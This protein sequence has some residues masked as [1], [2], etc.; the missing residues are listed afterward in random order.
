[1]SAEI[2]EMTPHMLQHAGVVSDGDQYHDSTAIFLGVE[3][4]IVSDRFRKDLGDV[5]EL[6]ESIVQVGLLNPITVES[7]GDGFRLIAGERRLTAYRKLGLAEIPAR[8][9]ED[10]SDAR[11]ALIAERDENTAR[12]EMLPSEKAALAMALEEMEKPAAKERQVSALNKGD[13]RSVPG[14]GTGHDSREVVA[15]AVDLSPSTYTRLKTLVNLSTDAEQPVEV[16][17]AAR[18]ALEQI[19]KGAPIRRGY[20]KVKEVRRKTESVTTEST[21]PEADGRTQRSEEIAAWHASL[22]KKYPT[23]KHAYE[24]EGHERSATLNAFKTAVRSYGIKYRFTEV[25]Y[26]KHAHTSQDRLYRASISLETAIGVFEHID[27]ETIT[28]E[29]AADAL[30]RIDTRQFNLIIRSLKEISNEQ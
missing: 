5:S 2:I 25:T 6:V 4:V 16:Q 13:S 17:E 12:K 8:V 3:D 14:N 28:K 7:T 22:A 23:A 29:Q 26:G 15:E 9:A 19:D 18:D 30:Q 27:L 11:D 24:A 10:I 21:A 1:M 20:D